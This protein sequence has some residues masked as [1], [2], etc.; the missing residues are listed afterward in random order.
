MIPDEA[1]EY[2]DENERCDAV[3]AIN[4]FGDQIRCDNKWVV[5]I[6]SYKYCEKHR[7]WDD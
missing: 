6:D 4:S 1:F 3:I 2:F 5:I 7:S